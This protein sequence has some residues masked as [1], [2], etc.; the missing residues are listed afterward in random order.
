MTVIKP[1]MRSL[2]DWTQLRNRWASGSVSRN[3]QNWRAKTKNEKTTGKDYHCGTTKGVSYAQG[4][5]SRKE[6][7]KRYLTITEDFPKL[8]NQAQ[9]TLRRTNTKIKLHLRIRYSKYRKSNIKNLKKAR[10][11]EEWRGFACSEWKVRITSDFLEN[12]QARK[13]GAKY[14]NWLERNKKTNL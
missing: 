4:N 7:E 9:R 3:V 14:L 10:K 12:M 2:I 8:L 5:T 1:L 13:S 11:V 6:E